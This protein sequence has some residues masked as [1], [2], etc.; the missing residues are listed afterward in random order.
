MFVYVMYCTV[1]DPGFD[2][3][4]VEFVNREWGVR[5]SLEMLTVE[6]RVFLA[7]FWSLFY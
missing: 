4:G 2:H 3:G 7:C 5:K 6:V 1:A